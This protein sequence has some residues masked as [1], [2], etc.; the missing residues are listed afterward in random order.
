MRISPFLGP[1]LGAIAGGVIAT[2]VTLWAVL[3]KTPEKKRAP[4]TETEAVAEPPELEGR[5]A[6]LERAVQR[7]HQQRALLPSLSS[8]K[9]AAADAA[10]SKDTPPVVDDPVFEAAVRDVMQR[11]EEEKIADRELERSER[12]RQMADEWASGLAGT[13][14]LTE[15]QKAK[16]SEIA[17]QFFQSAR[18]VRNAD[19]GPRDREAIRARV[20]ELRTQMEQK[21]GQV[22]DA[23][24]MQAYQAL[25]E[26]QRLG[27]RPG[28]NRGFRGEGPPGRG[29]PRND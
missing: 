13:L 3:P 8:A 16:V 24:Q 6:A 11:V 12:R 4:R 19:A 29:E 10:G 27:A 15:T 1:A 26:D 22:L 9:A 23:S 20:A 5:V 28:R 14:R 18:E 25:D 21:L 7:L 2:L 17:S